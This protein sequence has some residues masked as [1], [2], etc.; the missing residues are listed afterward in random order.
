MPTVSYRDYSGTAAENYQRYFVPAIGEPAAAALLDVADLRP[1][2]RV[3]DVAC[4][5]GVVTR[6]AAEQVGPSGSVTAVDLAPDMIE[7][8]RTAPAPT[9]PPIDWHVGDATTLPFPDASYD[10]VL[11]QMGLMFIEDRA[12]AVAEMHRV[13]APGGRVVV[14]TPGEIQPP[15]V[16]LE[17]ALVEH[18]NPD[19]GGFV[20]I[21][22]SM[23]DPDALAALLRGAGFQHVTGASSSARLHLPA[24][25]EFLWQYISVTPIAPLVA[26]APD[27]AKQAL[28][29][30]AVEA[31]QPYATDG[32]LDVEQPMVVASGRKVPASGGDVRGNHEHDSTSRA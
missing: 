25:A 2:E 4:G 11:C 1:G 26:Q 19:L 32:V 24:P 21:V 29:R 9:A 10:V 8:A 20:R 15:F 17:R 3:L 7:V 6:H 13:L 31:W 18:I 28:E 23:H 27:A 5:T 22:F 30:D 12:A 14:G 16:A